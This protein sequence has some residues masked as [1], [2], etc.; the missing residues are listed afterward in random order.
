M[1]YNIIRSMDI[2]NGEGVACSLFVQGC[3]HKCEGCFN[4]ETWN[5]GGGKEWTPNIENKFIDLCKK[6]YIDCVSILGGEPLQQ[7]E[8]MYNLLKRIKDEVRKPIYLWT[9][10]EFDEI[11]TLE[12]P[13]K[14]IEEKL[15][16]VLITGRFELNK[17]D[18]M[19]KLRGSSNQKIWK[20]EGEKY[21]IVQYL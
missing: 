3:N 21:D 18:L 5:W 10:Y 8:T 20:L 17:R 9:G 6:P 2:V 4:P 15:I 13:A 7:D 19:L 12:M 16:D 1:R 11:G 14:C